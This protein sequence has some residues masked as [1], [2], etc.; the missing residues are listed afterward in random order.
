MHGL[1]PSI[2]FTNRS[3][4]LDKN[5]NDLEII[6]M[7]LWPSKHIKGLADICS[8][9]Y[10][11][12][13]GWIRKNRRMPHKHKRQ[14]LAHAKLRC[15]LTKEMIDLLEMRMR[16][17]VKSRISVMQGMLAARAKAGEPIMKRSTAATSVE[18]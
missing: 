1:S 5:D 18:L 17:D 8:V 14:L 4:G 13:E 15:K 10:D 6:S 11:T 9:P 7:C 3:K 12:A 2:T 16:E